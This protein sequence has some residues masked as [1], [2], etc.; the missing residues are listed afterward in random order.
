[1]TGNDGE[2]FTD[3]EHHWQ[4]NL[5]KCVVSTATPLYKQS[6]CDRE[7]RKWKWNKKAIVPPIS[8]LF[9]LGVPSFSF[10][11]R[12]WDAAGCGGLRWVWG[13]G[14][15]MP[16]QHRDVYQPSAMDDGIV[17]RPNPNIYTTRIPEMLGHFLNLKRPKMKTKRI[18]NQ[19]S[20]HFIHNRT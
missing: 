17:Y 4:S 8:Y 20:Q 15:T 13:G 18:S 16:A 11:T 19:M 9:P 3:P 14:I 7:S 2:W 5:V 6:T 1:M 10:W 12:Y